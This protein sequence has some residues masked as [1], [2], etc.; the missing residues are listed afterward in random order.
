MIKKIV[1]GPYRS[2]SSRPENAWLSIAHN[3]SWVHP[4]EHGTQRIVELLIKKP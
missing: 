1:L 2:E 3:A 4:A